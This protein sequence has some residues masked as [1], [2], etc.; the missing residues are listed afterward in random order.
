M[1]KVAFAAA[2]QKVFFRRWK[3]PVASLARSPRTHRKR[4]LAAMQNWRAAFLKH[5]Y[6]RSRNAVSAACNSYTAKAVV[7]TA[8]GVAHSLKLFLQSC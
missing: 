8:A 1:Q 3:A 2:R 5:F 7:P 6:A 4:R